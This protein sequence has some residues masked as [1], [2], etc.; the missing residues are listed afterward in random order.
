MNKNLLMSFTVAALAIL[1]VSTAV[2]LTFQ[3]FAYFPT[4]LFSHI[5]TQTIKQSNTGTGS[6]NTQCNSASN[7]VTVMINGGTSSSTSSSSTC[8]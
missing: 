6:G 1:T 5:I 7:S 2:N 3:A 4:G 8:K